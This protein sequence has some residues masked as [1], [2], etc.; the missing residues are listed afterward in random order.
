VDAKP[1]TRFIRKAIRD[2]MEPLIAELGFSGKHPE[3]RR[4]VPG[5]IHFIHFFSAKYG[6]SFSLSGAWG[7]R[8]PNNTWTDRS[9]AHTDFRNRATVHRIAELWTV[10][11]T[12]FRAAAGPFEY[13]YIF[14]DEQVCRQ[15]VAE[16][17]ACLPAL[18]QWLRTQQGAEC[19]EIG[20]AKVGS[21][22]NQA[23]NWM[24]AQAKAR[25]GLY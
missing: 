9:I 15:L 23:L 11:G 13:R 12:P 10:D 8:S 7:M 4:E 2:L 14:D 16:A 3:Y 21:V 18:D 17:A 25:Q 19:L 6:G 20:G 1:T 22:Q 24:I 5:Q